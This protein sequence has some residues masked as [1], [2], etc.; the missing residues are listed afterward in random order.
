MNEEAWGDLDIS[1]QR[2]Q[3]L[4]RGYLIDA[5]VI[6]GE[7]ELPAEMNNNEMM[8]SGELNWKDSWICTGWVKRNLTIENNYER[9]S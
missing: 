3:E 9:M 2:D 7:C 6:F 5:P 4:I 8:A 1:E